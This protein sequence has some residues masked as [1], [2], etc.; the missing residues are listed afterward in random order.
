MPL[1]ITQ[2]LK[3]A[4][5]VNPK[6]TATI[7]DGRSRNWTEVKDRV[8]K[9][10]GALQD[11]GLKSDD[12]VAVIAF[13]SDRY[14]EL[15]YAPA[16]AG[17]VVVPVNIRLAP[18]EMLHV[19][20]DSGSR[21]LFVSDP[22][23]GLIQPHLDKV[24]NI[25]T[26]VYMGDG[27]APEGMVPYEQI[28]EKAQAV[29]DAG[30]ED[31]DLYA[32]MYTGGTTG[33]S[34]GVM[35]T[36]TNVV[37]N[38]M[39][40]LPI[41]KFD[42]NSMYMHASPM[43]HVADCAST[44]GLTTVGA[45]HLMIPRFTPDGLLEA[46][47][48]TRCNTTMLVPTMLN[49]MINHPKFKDHDLSSMKKILYGAS[50]MPEALIRKLIEIFP[51]VEWVQGL[52]MTEMSPLISILEPKHHVLE[53]PMSEKLRSVGYPALLN[54]IRIADENDKE[55]P[56]GEVGQIL[57]RGPMMMKGYWNL[58]ELTQE[59]LK[60]GWM[61]T[62]DSG[63]LDEDGFLYIVDR[64]KDMIITGGENV[65]S[66]EV[67][68]CIFK[69]PAVKECAVIGVPNE[70]WGELVHAIVVPKDG[71]SA[72]EEEIIQHCKGKIANYKVP[73]SVEFREE[74][75]PLSGAGKVLKTELRK[76]HWE[77]NQSAV[78]AGK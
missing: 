57:V 13:N 54:Q 72:T 58:P 76:P 42:Q 25:E 48:K 66:L 60:G 44:F 16:W 40:L 20:I 4:V 73:R 53:G 41:A 18:A 52:G 38:A 5:H 59:T 49:M 77:G 11:W 22:F 71:A 7:S 70:Q 64:V 75:L 23:A 29:P 3:R 47:E 14:L 32:L 35:L 68:E 62:G 9:L 24:P 34:K 45:T 78:H 19:L 27:E 43:F 6:G 37:T 2:G 17:T 33:K 26:V 56:T 10:A 28:L 15:L 36:H 50:P 12:R 65:Y 74:S 69:H 63:Y 39:C 46:I 8:S 55:L 21:I 61:H 31:E 1:S 51:E 30:R 67:E